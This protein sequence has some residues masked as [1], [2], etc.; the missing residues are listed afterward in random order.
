[1]TLASTGQQSSIQIRQKI[2]RDPQF[3]VA[4]ST[5]AE[6][7]TFGQSLRTFCQLCLT[8]ELSNVG[9]SQ[10]TVQKVRML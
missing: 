2:V 10:K 6:D 9:V 4:Y 3:T 7:K 5:V 8:C 1:M